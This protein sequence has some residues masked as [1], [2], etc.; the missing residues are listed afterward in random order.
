[1]GGKKVL[2]TNVVLYPI[3]FCDSLKIVVA[4]FM[5]DYEFGKETQSFVQPLGIYAQQTA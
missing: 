2:S 5:A 3:N 4:F 1:M